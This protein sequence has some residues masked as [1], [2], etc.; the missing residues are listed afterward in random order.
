MSAASVTVS[1]IVRP[2]GTLELADKLPLPAGKVQ[3]TVQSV[4]ELPREDPFFAMLE[5]IWAARAK[6]GL[7]PRSVEEMEAQRRQLRDQTA[8]E[9]QQAGQLQDECRRLRE[10]AANSPRENA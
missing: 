6:A 7:T 2:D 3:V 1:G 5:D 10:Q 8:E 9:V 4:P